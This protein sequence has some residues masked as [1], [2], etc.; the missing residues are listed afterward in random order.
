MNKL[1]GCKH[2]GNMQSCPVCND[3]SCDSTLITKQESAAEKELLKLIDRL[4][5]CSEDA[6][7]S[8]VIRTIKKSLIFV[9][10][11]RI[12]FAKAHVKAMENAFLK[13]SRRIYDKEDTSIYW[14]VVDIEN[15]KH[16]YPLE[17]I[18]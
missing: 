16:F 2:G 6:V 7:I 17:N 1:G 12:E 18:T 15:I 14:D 5:S 11:E 9:K 3:I 10:E 8:D 4:D 13:Q